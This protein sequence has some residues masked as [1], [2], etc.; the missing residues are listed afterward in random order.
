[1]QSVRSLPRLTAIAVAVLV[2]AACG[3]NV[4]EDA[5]FDKI[6]YIGCGVTTGIGAAIWTAGIEPGATV[7]V[8]HDRDRARGFTVTDG[9]ITVVGK[10][11]RVTP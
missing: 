3:R 7:G 4:R 9:G 8:D 1:M 11:V 6:C 5:P 10:G 2:L